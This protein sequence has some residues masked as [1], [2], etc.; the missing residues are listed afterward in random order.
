MPDE[1]SEY[2]SIDEVR[3]VLY[4]RSAAILNLEK[5]DVLEFPANMTDEPLQ[6]VETTDKRG[7][8]GPPAVG[9]GAALFVP[10]SLPGLNIS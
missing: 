4:P 9:D 6:A 8:G 3:S 10:P 7:S 5:Q 2:K 1:G